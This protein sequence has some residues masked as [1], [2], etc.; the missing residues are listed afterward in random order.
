MRA[1]LTPLSVA[2]ILV[3]SNALAAG[4]TRTERITR[5]LPLYMSGS[6]WVDNPVGSIEIVGTDAQGV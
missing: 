5:D 2:V 3:A 1:R 4:L 6:L